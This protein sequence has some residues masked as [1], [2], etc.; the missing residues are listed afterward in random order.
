[1][2]AHQQHCGAVVPAV[3]RSILDGHPEVGER[4]LSELTHMLLYTRCTSPSPSP[5]IWPHV[6]TASNPV[7]ATPTYNGSRCASTPQ[8]RPTRSLRLHGLQTRSDAKLKRGTHLSGSHGL[9]EGGEGVQWVDGSYHT[10]F[11]I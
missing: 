4:L 1:M 2:T 10:L 7:T 9:S 11:S 5:V 3:V 8:N 6:S